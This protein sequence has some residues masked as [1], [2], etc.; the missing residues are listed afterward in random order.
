MLFLL[1][2]SKSNNQIESNTKLNDELVSE[3][4]SMNNVSAQK[5]SYSLLN[6][7][8]RFFIWRNHFKN[9]VESGILTGEQAI[10]VKEFSTLL[11]DDVFDEKQGIN[12]L[13][14]SHVVELLYQAKK[15]FS[16]ELMQVTFNEINP[17]SKDE[18]IALELS[19]SSGGG[20]YCNCSS[21]SNYCFGRNPSCRSN[22]CINTTAGCGTLFIY[23]CNGQCT[24]LIP[25]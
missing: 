16:P 18:I 25:E 8:E 6:K 20:D 21:E 3:V 7:N 15:V 13:N 11:T 9:I 2:C 14:Q 17:V 1:S 19:N 5:L 4:I 22:G 10:I 24:S 12:F 23:S